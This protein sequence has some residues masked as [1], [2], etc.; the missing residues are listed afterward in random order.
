MTTVGS[1]RTRPGGPIQVRAAPA[2]E[3]PAVTRKENLAQLPLSGPRAWPGPGA[4]AAHRR[5]RRECSPQ[6]R[7]P[8][9]GDEAAEASVPG[10]AAPA[11]TATVTVTGKRRTDSDQPG[12]ARQLSSGPGTGPAR[13]PRLSANHSDRDSDS[14]AALRRPARNPGPALRL[15]GPAT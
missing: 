1:A 9:H 8:R 3:S 12:Q 10:G 7:Q 15:T 11:V 14:E 4:A 6:R 5:C 2:S 13:A